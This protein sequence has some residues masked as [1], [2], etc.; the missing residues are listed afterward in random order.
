[1]NRK[2]PTESFAGNHA[3]HVNQR[4]RK[5]ID[6]PQDILARDTIPISCGSTDFRTNSRLGWADNVGFN[7]PDIVYDFI[8][9]PGNTQ[10]TISMCGSE[11]DSV[12]RVFEA[13][14]SF[15]ATQVCRKH[16]K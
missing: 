15:L 13:G 6:F 8:N 1:M 5:L 12:I 16:F 14:Q 3:S 10:I 9:P 11:I 7:S 2:L 4:E